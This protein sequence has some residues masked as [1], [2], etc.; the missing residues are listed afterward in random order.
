MP[1]VTAIGVT[2]PP[3]TDKAV[4]SDYLP[5]TAP[6]ADLPKHPTDGTVEYTGEGEFNVTGATTGVYVDHSNSA[7]TVTNA[8]G[9]AQYGVN[10]SMGKITVNGYVVGTTVGAQAVNS[11]EVSIK[12]DVRAL[13]VDGIGAWATGSSSQIT[14]DGMIH[15]ETYIKISYDI[16]GKNDGTHDDAKPGYL[17]YGN[18]GD[19]IV[20]VQNT[21]CAIGEEGYA[22]L[23]DALADVPIDGEEPTIISLLK[24]IDHDQSIVLDNQ[25]ITFELNGFILNI[26]SEDEDHPALEVING[27][28]VVL[29]GVG[30]LNVKGKNCGVY[31]FSENLPPSV[32]TV[33][34]AEAKAAGGY[35]AF[36]DGKASITIL[37][38][39]YSI[40]TGKNGYGAIAY[41]TAYIHI[42]GEVIA[43]GTGV[44]ADAATIYVEKSISAG[45]LGAKVLNDGTITIDGEIVAPNYIMVDDIPKTKVDG[46]P[47]TEPGYLMY[48]GSDTD[49]AVRVKATT[50]ALTVTNGAGSGNYVEGAIVNITADAV[51]DGQRFKEWTGADGIEFTEGSKTT[52][53]VKF[54]MPAEAVTLTAAYEDIPVSI[55]GVTVSPDS[56]SVQKGATQGFTATVTGTGA[57]DDTVAWSVTGGVAGTS[58]NSSGMLTVAEDETAVTLTVIATAT[59][60]NSKKDTATVTVTDAPVI[61]YAL[62]VNNGS[63][64]GEYAEGANVVL[65]AATP[66]E[67]KLFD[68]WVVTSGALDLADAT[69]NPII[70]TMPA[71]AIIIAATYKDKPADP[72]PT[73]TVTLNGGGTGATGVGNYTEGTTVNIYAGSRSSYTFTGWTSSD[74]AITNASN[75]TTSFTMPAKNIT[76]T[77]NWSYNSGGGGNGGDDS[78]GGSSDGNDGSG[79]VVTPPAPSAP[80]A[81]TQGSVNIPGTVDASGNVTANITNQIVSDA[82]DRALAL[83]MQNSTE[84][85]GIILTLNISTG[86]NPINN[87][88]V[89][90]PKEVQD[91][92]IAKGVSGLT[93]TVGGS[94]IAIGMDLAALREMNRQAGGNINLTATRMNNATLAGNAR[95][96]IGIRPV[97]DLKANYG[98][99]R[100]VQN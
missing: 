70:I 13:N 56:T 40:D 54:K 88:T 25:K 74:V 72:D 21:V 2:T 43:S 7:V 33:T 83:A 97:F 58:I 95:A 68:K 65:T 100:T 85:N 34:S 12:G 1:I 45:Q 14:I 77:A 29:S 10:A 59:G 50:Y 41:D 49:S 67:D 62:T 3:T 8:M 37:E 46:V 51:P 75:K 94:D 22:T 76:V 31:A 20:W 96:A 48:S 81:P 53:T 86:G 98:N 60:D 64:T 24:S 26:Y 82:I 66:A 38:D 69:A 87:L 18:A 80:N 6:T 91:A 73:Y 61:K 5:Q 16:K 90:L 15:A 39:V 57:F 27:G 93:I 28:R 79:V 84:Q 17:K 63:G 32:V 47:D 55:T 44:E 4:V 42:K 78:N 23:G 52:P 35:A 92:I 9:T 11:G 36:A 89:N 99:G 30:E 71:E 19:G